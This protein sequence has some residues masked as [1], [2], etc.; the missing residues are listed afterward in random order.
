MEVLDLNVLLVCRIKQQGMKTKYLGKRADIGLRRLRKQ[1]CQCHTS[2]TTND[3]GVGGELQPSV[4]VPF[5]TFFS[6]QLHNQAGR[7]Q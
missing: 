2:I 3:L 4:E 5:F 6:P 7:C 1:E